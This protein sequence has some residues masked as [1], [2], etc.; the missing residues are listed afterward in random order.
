MKI[1]RTRGNQGWALALDVRAYDNGMVS[2]AGIPINRHPNYDAT[3]GWAGALEV[4][5]GQINEFRKEVERRNKL[6]LRKSKSRSA[7]AK[8][9]RIFTTQAQAR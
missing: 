1:G 5:V 7:L 8:L 4:V 2:V 9:A 6:V 3:N